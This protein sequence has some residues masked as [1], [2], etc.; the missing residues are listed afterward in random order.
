MCSCELEVASKV[1]EK[2]LEVRAAGGSGGGTE[3]KSFGLIFW[4]WQLE[5]VFSQVGL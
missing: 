4:W 2:I 5:Q 3:A 1:E